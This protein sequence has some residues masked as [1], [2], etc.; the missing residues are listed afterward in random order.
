MAKDIFQEIDVREVQA[1]QKRI[2]QYPIYLIINIIDYLNMNL[3]NLRMPKE[4]KSA[5]QEY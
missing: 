1:R 3:S 4:G 2:L 5:F